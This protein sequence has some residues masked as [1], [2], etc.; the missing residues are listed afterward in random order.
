M[1]DKRGG[2]IPRWP[3]ASHETGSMCGAHGIVVGVDA[4]LKG[5]KGI[6]A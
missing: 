3:F 4:I 6:D 2:V 1:G 5:V